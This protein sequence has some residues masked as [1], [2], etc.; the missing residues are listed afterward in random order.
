MRKF[1]VIMAIVSAMTLTA[2]TAAFGVSATMGND[3]VPRSHIDSWSHFTVV[4][5]NNP[6]AFDGTMAEVT[7]FGQRAGIVRFVIVDAAN[8]I[9]QVS[10]EVAVAGTGVET[11][12]LPEPMGVTTG[13]NLGVHFV[14]QSSIPSDRFVGEP[15][16]WNPQ[17]SA[18][19]VGQVVGT[20]G[21]ESRIYSMNAAI[22][23]SSPDVCKDGGWEGYGYKN[24][25]QCIASVV[26]NER[27]S[28]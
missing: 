27:A 18:P 17:G 3:A 2:V 13:A 4:D 10:D 20:S 16:Y 1:V 8:V 12:A 5:T 15:A 22:T 21:T 24:Q 6:A 26:A 11:L 19:T 7:V 25:G 23:A 28:K 9:T 14:G